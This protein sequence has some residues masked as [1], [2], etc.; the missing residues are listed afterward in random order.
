MSGYKDI[1][2]ALETAEI[3]EEISGHKPEIIKEP[4]KIFARQNLKN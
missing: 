3:Q 2:D 1:V 4:Q